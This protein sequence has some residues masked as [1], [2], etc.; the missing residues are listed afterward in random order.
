MT[1]RT[2][3]A[4]IRV[5][6]PWDAPCELDDPDDDAFADPDA[7]SSACR[8]AWSPCPEAFE[9]PEL[10]AEP[11][12]DPDPDDWSSCRSACTPC[13]E[14]FAEPEPPEAPWTDPDCP[15]ASS[16]RI[17]RICRA[18]VPSLEPEP[19]DPVCD[20]PPRA[21]R[22]WESVEDELAP[23]ASWPKSEASSLATLDVL[24]PCPDELEEEPP[25]G[26]DELPDEP[27]DDCGDELEDPGEPPLRSFEAR[28]TFRSSSRDVD[29]DKGR[30]PLWG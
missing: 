13:P 19:S 20:D 16:S 6:P 17:L 10:S 25:A 21:L 26:E 15:F 8:R 1:L 7:D 23:V 30:A 28:Y 5:L 18:A 27:C 14:A 4:G 9:E 3:S 12:A 22:I 29:E 24:F 11:W 2:S